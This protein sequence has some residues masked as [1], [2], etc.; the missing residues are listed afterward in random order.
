MRPVIAL[1]LLAFAA[2]A[3]AQVIPTPNLENPRLQ[4]AEWQAGQRI[5]LTTLPMTGL[6]VMFDTGER[7]VNTDLDRQDVWRLALS[8]EGASVHVTP[9]ARDARGSLTVV[10][11]RRAYQFSLQSDDTLNAALLVRLVDPAHEVPPP[12]Q[13]APAPGI[14]TPPAQSSWT[15][16]LKGD[17]SVRP[18]SLSDDGARTRI[19]FAPGQA[20]PA[21]FAIGPT[22]EEEVVNG[23]MRGDAFEIDRVFDRLVF[24]IDRD[25]ATARRSARPERAR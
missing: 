1:C 21:V 6:T 2:G 18:H 15:Y 14:F 19:L 12:L 17:H 7:I 13:P 5:A 22:G 4:T 25:K 23:Y 10:T 9:L 8:S 16:S 3:S 24:R 11:N 20:L